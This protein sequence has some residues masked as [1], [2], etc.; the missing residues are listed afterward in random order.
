MAT[1][2]YRRTDAVSLNANA[3]RLNLL[4]RWHPAA[5]VGIYLRIGIRTAIRI[6][7]TL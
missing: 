4:R 7:A 6:G 5:C 3:L 1:R 2:V